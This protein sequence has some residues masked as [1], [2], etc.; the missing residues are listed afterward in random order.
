LRRFIRKR[1]NAGVMEEGK[2]KYY[3]T[4]T[5]QG[6]VISPLLSNIFLHYVLD[7][8]FVKE[9][10]PCMRGRCSMIRWADDFIIG[11]ELESDA[12]RIMA[13]LPKRFG[14]YGLSLHPEK[15][16]IIR[17][18]RP[19]SVV[20]GKDRRNGTVDFLGFTFYWARSYRGYWV[21]KRKTSRR[22]LA[23]FMRELWR[24]CRENMHEP[25]QQQHQE[26][27]V[28]LR[29]WF[30]YHG[31]RNNYRALKAVFAC[32]GRAWRYWLSRRSSKGTVNWEKFA[33]LCL[34]YP[35]PRPRIIHNI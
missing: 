2:L 24:W 10:K 14:R 32:A 29:G 30:R 6:G 1:L 4:G 34:S 26:L 13:V 17:F 23:R 35:L 15:T 25:I 31:V 5:P 3:E 22:R 7:D 12:R 9:V 19:R 21:I 18:K 20:G 27:C 28:K 11:C 33:R 16:S 8:W